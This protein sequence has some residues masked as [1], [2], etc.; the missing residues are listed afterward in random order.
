MNAKARNRVLWVGLPLV[1]LLVGCGNY[2]ITFEAADVINA[3]GEDITREDLDVDVL[4]LSSNDVKNHPEIVNGTMRSDEWFKAR[5]EV[6]HKI[7]DISPKRIYALRRGAQGDSRDTLLGPSLLS[8][9][10]R[11]DGH[12]TTTVKV[13]H[14]NWLSGEAAIVIYGRFSSP[15]GVAQVPPLVVQ[16]P[17][18]KDDITI[19]VGRKGMSLGAR[20]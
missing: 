19:K 14:P 1:V 11:R 12:R 7:G 17:G 15:T 9:V 8:F 3:W 4:C 18:G 10:D 2:R 20:R 5:D 13:N 6:D 16:P